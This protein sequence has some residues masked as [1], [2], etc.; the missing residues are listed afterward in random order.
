M[1]KVGFVG[2]I[3][4][5]G[6]LQYEYSLDEGIK[7]NFEEFDIRIANLESALYD[8][9]SRC[10]V[11]M[12]DPTLGNIIYSPSNSIRVLKDL[13]INVV[14]LANNHT[15]DCDLDGLKET[16]E[17]LE[18]N[19][20][21]YFGA[22]RTKEEVEKPAVIYKNDKS[23]CFLGYFPPEWEAPYPPTEACG[24][25]NHFYIEKVLDDVKKKAEK[26][27]YVF[28]VPHWGKEHTR[29][30]LIRDVQNAKKII[31]AGATA[32]IGSHTHIVQPV[33]KYK[34][35]IIAMSLG[36]F[37]FPDRWIIPPRITYYPS[38]EERNAKK[39]PVVLGFPIVK[40]LSYKK[41]NEEN[42]EG[43]ILAMSIADRLIDYKLTYTQLDEKH[44]LKLKKLPVKDDVLLLVLSIL[45]KDKYTFFYRLFIKLKNRLFLLIK[46]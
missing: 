3:M 6:V 31:D 5:G 29:L 33:F 11:K 13:N 35:K 45:L 25:L 22:G 17:V 42:R 30:P 24:G 7:K 2:D 16:I 12:N 32:V 10:H 38:K 20:I 15:C 21:A 27:D 23:F 19:N 46:R 1:I 43:V 8:G 44:C 14:S 40:E 28:V 37:I 41:V 4:P 26:Y 36:N 34:K 18:K 39:H 9:R